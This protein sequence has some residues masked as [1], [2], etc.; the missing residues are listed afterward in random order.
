MT[1]SK[2]MVDNCFEVQTG[3]YSSRDGYLLKIIDKS[4]KIVFETP[5]KKKRYHIDL[6]EQNGSQKLILQVLDPEGN[7]MHME[8][9]QNKDRIRIS[10]GS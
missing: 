4:G 8:K 2:D 9:L 10:E 6:S 5:V 7:I 3:K 1:T